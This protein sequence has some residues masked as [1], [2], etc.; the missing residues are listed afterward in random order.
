MG[1][2]VPQWITYPSLSFTSGGSRYDWRDE[3][4]T[5]LQKW[6]HLGKIYRAWH[7]SFGKLLKSVCFVER[8]FPFS[9]LFLICGFPSSLWIIFPKQYSD[10]ILELHSDLSYLI[11]FSSSYLKKIHK[12]IIS[13]NGDRLNEGKTPSK[14]GKTWF[15]VCVCVWRGIRTEASRRLSKAVFSPWKL[16]HFSFSFSFATKHIQVLFNIKNHLPCIVKRM[17][18]ICLS[19]SSWSS[20]ELSEI[21]KHNLRISL[22]KLG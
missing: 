11:R 16:T 22:Q 9:V 19:Y 18:S 14:G 21:W 5:H 20:R 13:S 7:L 17:L 8:R 2:S 10:N 12:G 4:C 6:F 1:L 15:C 3:I